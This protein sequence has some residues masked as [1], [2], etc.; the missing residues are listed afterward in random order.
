[1]LLLNAYLTV[2]AGMPMS[3]SQIGWGIFTDMVIQK[4][5]EQKQHLV[6]LLWGRFAQEKQSLIDETRHLV[7]KAA[8]P[9]PFSAD[10]GFFGCRHFSKANN[11]LMKNGT[12]PVD[13]KLS[14]NN[15][16]SFANL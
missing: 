10:K 13:W 9:S 7:L 16:T 11:Y 15:Q 5:S 6:F 3:H 2:E 12:D 1:V 8:H 14:S 4:L